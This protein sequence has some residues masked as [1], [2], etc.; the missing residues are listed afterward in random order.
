M[1]YFIY[2]LKPMTDIVVDYVA[3]YKYLHNNMMDE[4]GPSLIACYPG[5]H[6][7]VIVFTEELH[8][9]IMQWNGI[10]FSVNRC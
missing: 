2:T 4:Y 5:L 6:G 10:N 3:T 7:Y 1:A 8:E 9:N